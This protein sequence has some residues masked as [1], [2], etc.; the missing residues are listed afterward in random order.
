MLIGIAAPLRQQAIKK[1]RG[2]TTNLDE[3]FNNKP[4][5][6]KR[7]GDKLDNQHKNL[8]HPLFRAADSYPT[9]M[10]ATPRL[11]SAPIYMGLHPLFPYNISRFFDRF[12]PFW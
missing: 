4:I 7:Q 8:M 2:K 3:Q 12:L 10:I 6:I 5:K 1:L 9:L 11:L